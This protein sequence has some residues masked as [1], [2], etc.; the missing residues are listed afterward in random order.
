[1]IVYSETK[2]R[3]RRDVFSNKIES[4]ILD[5]FKTKMKRSIGKSEVAS[6]KNSMQFMDRVLEDTAI[7]DDSRVG[8]EYTIPQSAKRIDFLLTGK[9][10]EKQDTVVIVELKQW[11]EV[12]PTA[13]DAIV[14]TAM[15]GGRVETEHPS[16]QAWTYAALL[17][18]YN[19]T[20]RE[21]NIRLFPC[22]YLHNCRSGRIVVSSALRSIGST[23]KRHRFSSARTPRPSA[24]S[25]NSTSN[26]ATPP[27]F[28][29]GSRMDA[30]GPPRT[31]RTRFCRCS[32][33]IASS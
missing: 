13:K 33:A 16:Y 25:S 5:L 18:D 17:E 9:N 29:I 14:R 23:Q 22:A 24:T 3:F 7:P 32:K 4:V 19:E 1:M 26:S 10:A 27:T 12:E 6:W 8:I 20:V 31:S 28:S 2:N 21:E 11:A 30:S 15:G